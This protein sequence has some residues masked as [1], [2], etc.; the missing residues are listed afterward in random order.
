MRFGETYVRTFVL[1]LVFQKKAERSKY[2]ALFK[3]GTIETPSVEYAPMHHP[4]RCL[5]RVRDENNN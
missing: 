4:L 1:S 5:G 3:V 2:F